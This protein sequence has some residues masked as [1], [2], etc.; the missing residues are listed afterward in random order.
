[1]NELSSGKPGILFVSPWLRD[2]GI[3]RN[4]QIKVPWFAQQGYRVAVLSWLISERLNGKPNPVLETFKNSSIPV[5][6]LSAYGK[7][8]LLQ[9]ALQVAAIALRGG[10]RIVI[11]HELLGNLVA[12]LAK[13]LTAGGVRVIAEIH[14]A[15]NIY[16][17]TGCSP[18]LLRVARFLYRRADGIIAA[19]EAIRQDAAEFFRLSPARIEKIYY[20][21]PL[22]TIRG[23]AADDG[24]LRIET[25]GRFIVGCGRLVR[26]KGFPDLIRAFSLVRSRLSLK[27]VILGDGPDR[28]D[29][30]RCA[31]SHS[32]GEDLVMPGFVS[33]PF[34]CFSRASAFVLSSHFG[35]ACPWVLLEAMACGVPVI[36]A[37]CQWGPE[38]ILGN[39]KFGLL[40][41]VGDVEGLAAGMLRLLERPDLAANFVEAA[42]RR[43]EDFSPEKILLQL[44]RCYLQAKR[45]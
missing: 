30:Q 16:A 36:A 2:G 31:E 38:E 43:V 26:M 37:R 32:V 4:L 18:A 39:G 21:L 5:R 10:F 13:L 29:L 25:T 24:A 6:R 14:N 34:A 1:M 7:S 12:I 20:P 8:Q 23:L 11:G 15:S 27:L 3:E 45:T 22:G 17:E 9:R 41:D 35:E 19:S 28:A 33:N 40:Y 42:K 44:E